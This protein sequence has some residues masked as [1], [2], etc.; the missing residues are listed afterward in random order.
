MKILSI[1]NSFSEDAQRYLHATAEY[2]GIDLMCANL[3]IGGCSLE[4]HYDNLINETRPYE[5]SENAE[6]LRKSTLKD[7]IAAHEWD[8]ITLQQASHLSYK[9]ESYFPYINE[10]VAY[11]RKSC[12]N[13]KI[14]IHQTWSYNTNERLAS[15]K[16][17]THA[18]MF[19]Y[20]ERAY[21][22][23][24]KEIDADGFIPAGE[25]LE[26]LKNRGFN[27][28]RD[29]SHASLGL[30]RFA[31]ALTWLG[32]IC[33]YDITKV[34][35]KDF[36]RF[37]SEDEYQAAIEC[38]KESL[39]NGKLLYEIRTKHN[40]PYAVS[41]SGTP[42]TNP[43]R[44]LDIYLPNT[45]NFD[46]FV[47][48]HGGGFVNGDKCG[49]FSPTVAKYF[50]DNG[51]AYVS[52]NYRM[53]PNAQYPDFI[54][55]AALAVAYVKK[56]IES[57]GGNGRVFVGG[58]S[59]GG[60]LSQMLCFDKKWLAFNNIK[61]SD[62]AGFVHDAGQPTTHF[63]VLRERGFDRRKLVVDEAAPLYY[64]GDAENY[65]PMLFILADNDMKNRPEQTE[66]LLS[67]MRHFGYDMSRVEKVVIP[68]STH[69]SYCKKLDEK[70]EPV[71]AK[72]IVEYL[73]KVK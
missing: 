26:R 35:Y 52:A 55:D 25:T 56:N 16:F 32:A 17:G 33:G 64:V 5:Y 29:G 6:Y 47:Y 13:A 69:S 15:H 48:F 60:Y 72:V 46:T 42:D 45:D 73:K 3:F 7:G 68:D 30:G 34:S 71:F 59:A 36:D 39:E 19:S 20:V 31:V 49:E 70:G 61:V 51:F 23:A 4:T 1:G 65:P 66:L 9:E 22:K 8:I 44:A 11:L 50:T 27:P 67:T 14:Y 41:H 62:I 18:D 58:T 38:A 21:R 24:E 53:Y 28:H 63:N 54:R 12:P 40:V 10:L 37:V 57:F 2:E 43:E